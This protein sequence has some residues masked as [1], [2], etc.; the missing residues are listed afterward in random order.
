MREAYD[1]GHKIVRVGDGWCYKDNGEPVDFSEAVPS[2]R[3]TPTKIEIMRS[4]NIQG[5]LS[6]VRRLKHEIRC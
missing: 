3:K 5:L 1:R 4:Q 2:R 6:L